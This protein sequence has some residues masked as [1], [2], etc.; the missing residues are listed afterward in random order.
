MSKKTE[1]LRQTIDETHVQQSAV[2]SQ[3]L[4]MAIDPARAANLLRELEAIVV[5]R[6]NAQRELDVVVNKG[7]DPW[8]KSFFG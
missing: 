1:V 3:V 2:Y 5:R 7:Y 4:A 6:Q 8:L